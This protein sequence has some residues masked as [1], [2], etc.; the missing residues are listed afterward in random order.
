VKIKIFNSKDSKINLMKFG[1]VL[2][3]LIMVFSYGTGHAAAANSNPNLVPITNPLNNNLY[4][5]GTSGNDSNMG[6]AWSS[7]K[8]TIG[9]AVSNVNDGGTVHI[10]SGTYT[11]TGNKNIKINENMT[12]IGQSQINTIINAQ[13]TNQI[14]SIA[15]GVT[16]T[17]EDLTLTNG[18]A[19]DGGAIG[20]AGNL[21][22]ENCTFS[23]NTADIG[24][25]IENEYGCTLAIDNCNFTGNSGGGGGAIDNYSGFMTV[26]N[27]TFIGNTL[28]GGNGGPSGAAINIYGGTSTI[29][30][31]RI[32]GNGNQISNSDDTDVNASDNWWGSNTGPATG[33]VV[34]ATYNPWLVL[35]I[36][37]NPTINSGESTPVIAYLIEDSNGTYHYPTNGHVPDGLPVI[38]NTT[39]GTINNQSTVDGSALST[40]NG[41]TNAGVAFVSATVDGQTVNTPVMVLYTVPV[42]A[43]AN[44]AGGVFNST[45]N[46]TLSMNKPGTIYYT[47]NGNTP[48]FNSNRYT[49]P[50]SIAT[51]KTLEFFAMDLAGDTSPIYTDIYIITP[52]VS[53]ITPANGA[54]NVPTNEVINVTFSEPVKIVHSSG[55]MLKSSNGAAA[56]FTTSINGDVLTIT[57]TKQ[58]TADTKYTLTLNASSITDLAGNPLALWS[59]SFTVD[60]T[61]KVTNFN[62]INGATNVA[63][64]KVITVTFSE[65]IKAGNMSIQLKNSNGT[66]IPFKSSIKGNTLTITP[67]NLLTKGTKYTLILH[68]GCVTDSV[69][70]T[71]EL[72]STYFTTTKT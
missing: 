50:I 65:P 29:Q 41:G 31:N 43:S 3:G 26:Y 16:V 36:T 24:G 9:N 22:L 57:P 7:A 52:K 33:E 46:V 14:F 34:D 30:F 40:L 6:W 25:A 59:S 54:V 72:T 49:S 66:I 55:I 44:P 18:S 32:I 47:T 15:S 70:N 56:S 13:G 35:T 39:S 38:F 62:P 8:Q 67:T 2:I 19:A 11:G 21:T 68:T 63:I 28:L 17:F 45:Q 61:P 53:S 37:A 48:T 10:A 58:L 1:L 5:N 64:N 51:N 69:G 27:S 42:T 4:V 20:N 60:P 12:I 23:G 71:L